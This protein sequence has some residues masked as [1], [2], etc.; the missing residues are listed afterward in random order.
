MTKRA[1]IGIGM[2]LGLIWAVLVVWL[3]GQG[4]QPFIPLNMALIFAFAPGG[5]VMLLMIGR[6]AQR[7]FFDDAI[8]D[9]QPFAT[10]SP[11]EI[12]QRVLSNT[13]EQMVLALCLW[14]LVAISLG[15]VTVI[16]LGVSMAVARVLFWVGYHLSPPLRALGFAATFYPTVL[17]TL[18][19]LW[20]YLT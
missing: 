9:G 5:V 13:F 10:G 11:A 4:P 7:R 16:A 6:L 17:A 8:I 2:A 3:P 19:T 14:P 12:D 15:A 18:L 1:K 20:R